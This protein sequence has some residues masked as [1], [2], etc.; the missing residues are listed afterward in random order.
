MSSMEAQQPGTRHVAWRQGRRLWLGLCRVCC[1][2]GNRTETAHWDVEI[3]PGGQRGRKQI[4]SVR[5]ESLSPPCHL[6]CHE[7]LS[8]PRSLAPANRWEATP[9]LPPSS[10]GTWLP[11]PTF[12][13][14]MDDSDTLTL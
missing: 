1:P 4:M 3:L 13:A 14:D 6:E 10:V 7:I 8:T 11:D 9:R 5:R 2:A 12:L